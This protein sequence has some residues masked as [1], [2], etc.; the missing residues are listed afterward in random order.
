MLYISIKA[1]RVGSLPAILFRDEQRW[2]RR[3]RR[4]RNGLLNSLTKG[5][6]DPFDEITVRV[7][8]YIVTRIGISQC[9]TI[10]GGPVFFVFFLLL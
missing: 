8:F 5:P 9:H 4:D 10:E 2:R 7:I 6:W 3:E 1:L